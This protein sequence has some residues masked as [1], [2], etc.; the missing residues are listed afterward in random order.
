MCCLDNFVDCITD[1]IFERIQE[2]HPGELTKEE[3]DEMIGD[4]KHQ[5]IEYEINHSDAEHILLE[6]GLERAINQHIRD[7]GEIPR[8]N[9]VKIL[10]LDAMFIF[11]D[12]H[13]NAY[14]EWSR[15]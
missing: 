12:T 14:T 11:I 5:E 10:L 13:Y 7:F 4:I 6:Y 3:Y 1:H 15:Q 9:T 2:E 8:V